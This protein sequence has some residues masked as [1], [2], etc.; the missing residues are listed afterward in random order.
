VELV[1]NADNVVTIIH[2][3]QYWKHLNKLCLV[4]FRLSDWTGGR[5]SSL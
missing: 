4:F 5:S 1:I 2:P 3:V